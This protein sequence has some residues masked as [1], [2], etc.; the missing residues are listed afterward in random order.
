MADE[1]A[2]GQLH[3]LFDDDWELNLEENPLFATNYG[4]RRYNDRLPD[5]IPLNRVLKKTDNVVYG[6]LNLRTDFRGSGGTAEQI[7]RTLNGSI[8][9][10]F[11]SLAVAKFVQG[12]IGHEKNYL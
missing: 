11:P 2:T 12:L 9:A 4:D 7:Q 5:G 6:K 1:N 10:D 8:Y 3:K